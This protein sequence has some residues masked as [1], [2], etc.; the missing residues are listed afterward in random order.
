[1]TEHKCSTC[2][3]SKAA[4]DFYA[5][6]RTASGRKS[7]CKKCHLACAIASRDLDNTR[8]LNREH[9][10]RARLADPEKFLARDR[11]HRATR[12]DTAQARARSLLNAAVRSRKIERPTK[13]AECE[14]ECTPHG[15]HHDY[16]KPLDVKWL[17]VRCHSEE[18]IRLRDL[19][20][21]TEAETVANARAS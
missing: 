12:S 16:S 20:A 14:M 6:K 3:Q 18:H 1:M 13:C 21:T 19:E 4:G 2:K 8:R 15:H 17:C 10:A 9:M 11:A 7:Q 5:D